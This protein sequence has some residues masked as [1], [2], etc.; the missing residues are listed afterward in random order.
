M[1][2]VTMRKLLETGVVR[3][4]RVHLAIRISPP[5]GHGTESGYGD[6]FTLEASTPQAAHAA[7]RQALE[8]HE[9]TV[10]HE[11]ARLRHR[12]RDR[13]T[14]GIVRPHRSVAARPAIASG[15]GDRH[16]EAPTLAVEHHA[17]TRNLLSRE[18]VRRHLLHRAL[19]QDWPEALVGLR[20]HAQRL[21]ERVHETRCGRRQRRS[22]GDGLAGLGMG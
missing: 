14:A 16:A 11:V 1:A 21:V 12:D 20:P 2:V 10:P 5:G 6:M 15:A 13:A 4:P 17:T 3:G 22:G 18:M 8:F 9:S 7:M 19:A